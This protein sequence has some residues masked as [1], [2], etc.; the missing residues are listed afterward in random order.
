MWSFFFYSCTHFKWHELT[1]CWN[2][3]KFCF[4]FFMSPIFLSCLHI[5]LVSLWTEQNWNHHTE[6][7]HVLVLILELFKTTKWNYNSY[8][9]DIVT[10]NPPPL[11][12]RY[13]VMQYCILTW[14]I[15]VTN[16]SAEQAT[17]KRGA[18]HDWSFIRYLSDQELMLITVCAPPEAQLLCS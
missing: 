14:V 6:L 17:W 7:L 10:C 16:Y 3:L 15:K 12:P 2:H 4:Y 8:C 11:N 1:K 18:A 9:C 5:V 13:G